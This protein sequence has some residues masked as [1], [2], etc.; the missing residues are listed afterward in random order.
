MIYKKEFGEGYKQY[1]G[2]F[3]K[4]MFHGVGAYLPTSTVASESG[5]FLLLLAGT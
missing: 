3:K 1:V 5:H 2:Q 4:G